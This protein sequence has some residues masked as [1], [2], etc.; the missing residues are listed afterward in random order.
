MI[1]NQKPSRQHFVSPAE[2]FF[3]TDAFFPA[4][5]SLHRGEGESVKTFLDLTVYGKPPVV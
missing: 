2:Q 5:S 3:L 1:S 4:G